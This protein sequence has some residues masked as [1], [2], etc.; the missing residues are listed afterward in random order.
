MVP[1]PAMIAAL[2]KG[3][4]Q[5]KFDHGHALVLAGGVG[6][7]GAAR[8]AARA[9]LRVGAGLVTVACPPAAL[10]ENAGRLDAVMVRPLRDGAALRRMLEDL[11]ISAICLGPG[12]GLGARESGLLDTVRDLAQ[13][14]DAPLSVMLDADALTLL[15]QDARLCQALPPGC[16]LTPHRGEF[17]RMFPDLATRLAGDGDGNA[18]MVQ[19]AAARAGAV[20]LLKGACTLIAAP[21]GRVAQLDARGATATPWLATAGSGDVLA[22]VVTGLLAR[23]VPGFDAARWASFL[24]IE[25]ARSFGPGLIAE[26]LPEM[27]PRVFQRLGV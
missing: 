16:V 11:R 23:G 10:L 26:D 19:D 7:G 13:T 24:H 20:V 5:H 6:R 15:A 18:A 3:E 27:L 21:D 17:A 9:G 25:A 8:L 4:W 2:R 12:L 22:G 14:R 1:E